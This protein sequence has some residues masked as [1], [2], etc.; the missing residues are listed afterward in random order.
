MAIR[1]AIR[2]T[3]RFD[4]GVPCVEGSN[5]MEIGKAC[6]TYL[7]RTSLHTKF[8]LAWL[9]LIDNLVS[10]QDGKIM[11]STGVIVDEIPLLIVPRRSQ[12]ISKCPP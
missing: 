9:F 5:E 6:V 4:D 11:S 8:S 1:D 2:P 7:I 12:V 3:L 10:N